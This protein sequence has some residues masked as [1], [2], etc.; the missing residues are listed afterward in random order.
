[1]RPLPFISC[2]ALIV[3]LMLPGAAHASET[4]KFRVHFSPNTLGGNATILVDFSI[5]T[6]NGQIPSPLTDVNLRL[7]PG[8]SLGSST[9][10]LATCTEGQLKAGG[11][12]GCSPNALMGLGNATVEVPFGPIIVAESVAVNIFMGQAIN[13]HTSLLFY[14][15]AKTPVSAQLVFPGELL[16][17]TSGNFA[18]ELNTVI[19]LTPS[20]PGASYAAVVRMHSSV[21][22]EHLLYTRQSHG[23]TVYFRPVGI[24]IPRKCPVGGFRFD[25]VLTFQDGSTITASTSVPCPPRARKRRRAGK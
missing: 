1:M 10:G 17:G 2:V 9:L 15:D 3:G 16:E 19:P 21:G 22:P 13:G 25:A 5:A 14:A 7:P 20:V 4:A 18:A 11:L 8:V 12:A 23:R 24:A 6:S